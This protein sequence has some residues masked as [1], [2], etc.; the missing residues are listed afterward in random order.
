MDK[1]RKLLS[2]LPQNNSQI[3]S[4]IETTDDPNRIEKGLLELLPENPYEQ[5]RY[6]R[7]HQTNR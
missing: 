5:Y 1:I 6:E 7:Y 4:I 3:P 2:Y